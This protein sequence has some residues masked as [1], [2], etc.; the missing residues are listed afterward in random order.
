MR[1]ATDEFTATVTAPP[2]PPSVIDIPLPAVSTLSLER[3][4]LVA[5]VKYC[6]SSGALLPP[7]PAIVMSNLLLAAL[8]VT[9]T[10]APKKR[11]VR[12]VAKELTLTLV[13]EKEILDIYII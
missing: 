12:G 9:V 13:S 1:V 2:A 3:V 7:P 5:K 10:P 8:S 6:A 4:P 11:K